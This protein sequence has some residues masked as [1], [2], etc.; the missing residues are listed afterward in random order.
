MPTRVFDEN[1]VNRSGLHRRPTALPAHC[2]TNQHGNAHQKVNE[3]IQ[4]RT[5]QKT[6]ADRVKVPFTV[7]LK[8][9]ILSMFTV[10]L[11]GVAGNRVW[12]LTT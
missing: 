9:C 5:E 11:F 2:W 8:P 3:V 4:Q 7:C 10:S 12:P 1:V 6:G